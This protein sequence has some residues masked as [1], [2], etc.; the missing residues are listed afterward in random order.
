MATERVNELRGESLAMLES[1]AFFSEWR[2]GHECLILLIL[3]SVVSA[4]AERQSQAFAMVCVGSLRRGCLD[5]RGDI[6][7]CR[8]ACARG[9]C[10]LAIIGAM[11]VEPPLDSIFWAIQRHHE[12]CKHELSEPRLDVMFLL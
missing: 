1:F 2:T 6:L 8:V 10:A 5:H 7:S 11:T 3:A 9:F 4:G 12:S